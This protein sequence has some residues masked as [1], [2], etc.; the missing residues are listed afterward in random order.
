MK[1]E[2]ITMTNNNIESALLQWHPELRGTEVEHVKTVSRQR[3]TGYEND[4]YRIVGTDDAVVIGRNW[5][6]QYSGFHD[7]ADFAPG[8]FAEQRAYGAACREASRT[9]DLPV[10]V[11]LAIGPDLV[12]EFCLLVEQI[13]L[14]PETP[15]RSWTADK[16]G[17]RE[18]TP[19]DPLLYPELL[20]ELQNCGIYRRKEATLALLPEASEELVRRIESAGQVNSRRVAGYLASLYEHIA[21]E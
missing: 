3:G 10:E 14:A 17:V 5:Y 7:T 9:Y 13:R 11:C 8:Y 4:I 21:A 12:G 16:D 1:I 2:K 18:T 6:S 20:H 19:K 15:A